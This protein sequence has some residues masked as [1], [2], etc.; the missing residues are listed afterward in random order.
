MTNLKLNIRSQDQTRK[1]GQILGVAVCLIGFMGLL[2]WLLNID[3]LKSIFL[4]LVTMK[5]NTA[6]AFVFAGVALWTGAKEKPGET[7]RTWMRVRRVC[8][9]LVLLLGLL[10]L[11]EYLWGTNWGIDQFLVADVAT[12]STSFPGRMASNTALNFTLFGIA[13]WLMN[14]DGLIRGRIVQAFTLVAGSIAGIALIGY[15]YNVEALYQV[16]SY[17]SMAL[18]TA[19]SF[20]LL[21]NG[22]L[23][24][25]PERGIVSLLLSDTLGGQT[26]RRLLPFIIGVPL[27]LGLLV[28]VGEKRQL[29]DLHFGL[30]LLVILNVT[31]LTIAFWIASRWLEQIDK[32]RQ[33]AET[34]VR[35]FARLYATLSQVNQTIVRLKD[36][37]ELF[38]AICKVAIEFGEFRLAWIGIIDHKTGVIEP[39]AVQGYRQNILPFTYINI[40]QPPFEHGLVSTAIKMGR[41]EYSND[42]QTDPRLTYWREI[43]IKDDYHSAAA[44]PIRQNEQIV[45]V[46]SLCAADI[47]FFATEAETNLLEEIGLDISFAMEAIHIEAERQKATQALLESEAN[48]HSILNNMMEGCQIIDFDWRYVYVNDTVAAQGHYRPDQLLNHT[49][50][51]MY[52]GIENTTLFPF[53]RRCMEERIPERM[54]NR[55]VFPDGSIGWFELSIQPAPQGIFILSTDISQRKEAELA[56]QEAREQLEQR[57]QERTAEVQD[58]FDNAPAG[59][60]SL[61]AAGN[62]VRMNQTELSWLGYTR[63]EIVGQMNLRQ[64]LT[65]QSQKTFATNFPRFKQAG[66][67]NDLEM[68][69]VRRDGTIL[70]V[71]VNAL[72]V[73]DADGNYV[74]SR[75]TVVD[76]TE[77][78]QAEARLRAANA[79]LI[80]A[81]TLKDEFLSGMSHELRTPLNGILTLTETLEEGVYGDLTS[82]QLDTLHFITESGHHL[83]ALINDILDLSKIEAGKLE[84]ELMLVNVNDICQLSL[85][86]IKSSA[87]QKSLRVH[88]SVNKALESL[89]ADERRLKQMLVNLLSNA[90]K[91]T[92]EGGEIGLDVT[93][94]AAL[95]RIR[96]TVWD[97]GIGIEADKLP[98]LFQPFVQ[99][100]SSLSRKHSG[101][102]L[103]LSMVRR[104]AELHGGQVGVTSEPGKGSRF[105][106]DLPIT[107]PFSEIDEPEPTMPQVWP[108]N[109]PG[110]GDITGVDESTNM[111]GAE[112][113]RQKPLILLAEDNLVNQQGFNDYLTLKGYEVVVAM[114]GAEAL[115][116]AQ[117]FNPDLILMDVQMPVMN[118]LEAMRH[119]RTMPEFAATPIIA[120]T[121]LA[122]PGDRERCLEA[123]ANDCVTKPTSLKV[124]TSLI[125]TLL[126]VSRSGGI[127]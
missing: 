124:L 24:A 32:E 84:M 38:A 100:D 78:K 90:V 29:F 112:V 92:P 114:N 88:Y 121:A 119:L 85:R 3:F 43:A 118:G 115:A 34:Q 45:A 1:I 66:R 68:E 36:P 17:S 80:H 96:F 98:L 95:A 102:G 7:P 107:R 108:T 116:Q 10:T 18:H 81:A 89:W 51:E 99:L 122:M 21:A 97:M 103:G 44:I 71:A 42:M 75:S 48:Y 93:G 91:F 5:V 53:L 37:L 50:M 46:L 126:L 20:F 109:Q 25:Q 6:L 33:Q 117:Q 47:N 106:I 55:L 62:F 41:V 8:A 87:T 52:P 64:I 26:L 86:M 111:S 58:L 2:G 82:R 39:V 12:P 105:Y 76:I 74:M 57:V 63:A 67:L 77:R 11:I 69:F 127:K 70:P 60:H 123:G 13:L 73:Y 72:A 54:E 125:E 27:A 35:F 94:D 4:E 101:T 15:L 19:L 104:L 83:L 14:T 56:L 59:Y 40:G 9:G 22:L 49:L 16:R 31:I 23:L 30:A 65:L 110:R 61:D 28:L 113:N 79:E 120:L